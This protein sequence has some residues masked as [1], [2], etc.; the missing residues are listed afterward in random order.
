MISLEGTPS[1][2][3]LHYTQDDLT[4]GIGRVTKPTKIDV[5]F[6]Q[7]PHVHDII[8]TPND[9]LEDVFRE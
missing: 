6:C 3:R 9:V 4:T 7:N 5:S 2:T 8:N 1:R